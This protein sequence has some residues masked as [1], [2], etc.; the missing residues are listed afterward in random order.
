[1]YSMTERFLYFGFHAIK[2]K[3]GFFVHWTFMS[4]QI[5]SSE[6]MVPLLLVQLCKT[7]LSSLSWSLLVCLTQWTTCCLDILLVFDLYNSIGKAFLSSDIH[8]LG[9]CNLA[10]LFST[11]TI[12]QA[13]N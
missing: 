9:Y 12:G 8:F 3:G 5:F 6:S 7:Y 1:V 2:G 13:V 4:F 10:L 11:I